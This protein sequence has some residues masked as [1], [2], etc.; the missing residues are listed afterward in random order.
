MFLLDTDHLAIVQWQTQPAFSQLSSRM[1]AH[2]SDDFFVSIASFHEQVAGWNTYLS[3]ATSPPRVIEAYRRFH[4]ILSD[5]AAMQVLL[6]DQPVSNVFETLRRQ[7]VRVGTMDLRI[8]A[9]AIAHRLTLLSRNIKDF[10]KV[11]GLL[12]EDWT[13]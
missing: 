9:T 7:R 11:P 6:F 2:D 1:A 4:R 12:V 5:F 3:R 10:S 13:Q 8:A